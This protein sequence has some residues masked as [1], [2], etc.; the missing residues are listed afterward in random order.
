[1]SLTF[2]AITYSLYKMDEGIDRRRDYL[3]KEL[4]RKENEGKN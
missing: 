2:C 3:L 4:D 1:M